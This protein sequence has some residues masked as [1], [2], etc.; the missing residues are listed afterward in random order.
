MVFELI[1]YLA[2]FQVKGK[3][4]SDIIQNKVV[5]PT[6]THLCWFIFVQ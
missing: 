4:S 3:L 2:E 1:Y 6:K 5:R